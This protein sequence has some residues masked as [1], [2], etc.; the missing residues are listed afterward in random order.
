MHYFG[1]GV[2]MDLQYLSDDLAD[3]LEDAALLEFILNVDS[4]KQ[5]LDFTVYL[6]DALTR[7]ID[8]ETD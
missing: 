7:I 4:R 2:W 3:D 1:N 6:R 5:D 8:N